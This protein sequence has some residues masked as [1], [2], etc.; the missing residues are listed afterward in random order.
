MKKTI[1]NHI[2]KA[3]IILYMLTQ[4]SFSYAQGDISLLAGEYTTLS[5]LNVSRIQ[6]VGWTISNTSVVGI[7]STSTYIVSA[8]IQGLSE[9]T[10]TI[11][12]KYY[13]WDS[14]YLKLLNGQVKWKVTVTLPEP[15]SISLKADSVT[16]NK[17]KYLYPDLYPERA[18]RDLTWESSDESIVQV[19]EKG[20]ITG[21]KIGTADITVTTHNGLSSTSSITVHPVYA[22]TVEISDIESVLCGRPQRLDAVIAPENATFKEVVWSTSDDEIASIEDGV[23][24]PKQCGEVIVTATSTDD[25]HVSASRTV[26]I[27]PVLTERIEMS[28]LTAEVTKH[29]SLVLSAK[30][31]PNDVT[32]KDVLWV[33]SDEKVATVL[34][35]VVKAKKPGKATINAI[36]TDGTALCAKCDVTVLGYDYEASF[37]TDLPHTVANEIYIP[38][39]IDYNF[40]A[41]NLQFDLYL[42]EDLSLISVEGGDLLG[43]SHHLSI[44]EMGEN[45]YR[46]LFSSD[47]NAVFVSRSGLI[48]VLKIKVSGTRREEKTI[49]IKR[50]YMSDIDIPSTLFKMSDY[51]TSVNIS[52]GDVNNDGIVN[53]KDVVDAIRIRWDESSSQLAKNAA[54]VNGD[55]EINDADIELILNIIFL[56]DSR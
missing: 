12:A 27:N 4:G 23:L 43:S 51:S 31:Y 40:P 33:S 24:Y 39:N 1:L 28:Q 44:S 38:L 22:E 52:Y 8:E 25:H 32:S 20:R 29:D 56:K 3:C 30:L 2:F 47:D 16:I 36:T 53:V 19:D 48:A 9:G 5:Y 15:S 49:S 14:S 42:P 21:K 13:Y 17:S 41:T 7:N 37:S 34:N 26:Q 6:S 54:D 45:L 35:G 11:T 55:G 10:A 18:K 46:V 50:A